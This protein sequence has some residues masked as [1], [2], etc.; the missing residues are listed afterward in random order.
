MSKALS[1]VCILAACV[2]LARLAL[3]EAAR[4][5]ETVS[6]ATVPEELKG[7][8]KP[9]LKATYVCTNAKS[10]QGCS[11]GCASVSFSPLTRLTVILGSVTIGSQ[12]IPMYHY[13]A[14]FPGAAIEKKSAEQTPKAKAEAAIATK[15]SARESV[16]TQSASKAEGF[17]LSTGD[18]CGTVNMTL[19]FSAAP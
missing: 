3:S 1:N 4:A 5:E 18:V 13:L 11:A 15:G 6:P 19:T 12:V 2:I 9:I 14:E 16:H 10:G 17:V 7:I 8:M